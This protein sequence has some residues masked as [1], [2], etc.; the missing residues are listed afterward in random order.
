VFWP[1]SIDRRS[2]WTV[3]DPGPEGHQVT[4]I[5]NEVTMYKQCTALYTMPAKGYMSSD[6]EQDSGAVD[7]TG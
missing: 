3:V 2:E 5:E 4:V 6:A 1:T 7:T